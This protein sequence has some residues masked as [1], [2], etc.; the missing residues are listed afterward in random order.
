MISDIKKNLAEWVSPLYHRTNGL[1]RGSLD[2]L[3]D[4]VQHFNDAR[5]G[6]AAAGVA[7]YAIFSLFPLLLALIVAGS[8]VLEIEQVQR[9]VLDLVAEFLPVAQ[10]LIERNIRGVL[11]LRGTVGLVALLGLVWSATGVLTILARNINRAWTEAPP[12]TFVKD[13]LTALGM[14]TGLAMLLVLSLLSGAALDILA[15][16]DV[17]IGDG[18]SVNGTRLWT[19]VLSTVPHLFVFFALLG[20]YRW[21]PNTEVRW[22]ESLWGA[23]VAT[24]AG[25]IAT[26][27]FAWYLSSGFAHYE[28]VYG[29]VGAMVA[30][31]LWIYIGVL[32]LLFGTHISAAVARHTRTDAAGG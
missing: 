7:F 29:S 2:I 21:V 13:R 9:L 4:T 14:V 22:S 1:T 31:M 8:F 27:G 15:R 24:P 23:L 28:L 10:L 20:L 17:S 19:T 26:N 30:L 6:E 5:A 18:V 25:E 3:R 32:I 12:R 16:L 11:E